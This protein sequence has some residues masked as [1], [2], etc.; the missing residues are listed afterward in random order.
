M[1]SVAL[2]SILC[3]LQCSCTA[4]RAPSDGPRDIH[5]EIFPAGRSAIDSLQAA[6]RVDIW[7]V[8]PPMPHE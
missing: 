7:R 6:T 3:L 4:Y 5:V 2:I 8:V 1:K